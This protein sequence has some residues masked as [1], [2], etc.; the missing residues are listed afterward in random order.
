MRTIFHQLPFA[1]AKAQLDATTK[2]A[3]RLSLTVA[4]VAVLLGT[5]ARSPSF[6]V[7]PAIIGVGLRIAAFFTYAF[8]V[9]ANS[10]VG[11]AAKSV[12]LGYAVVFGPLLIALTVWAWHGAE[13]RLAQ[14][15]RWLVSHPV[16]AHHRQ[17]TIAALRAR[18]AVVVAPVALRGV[19]A[20]AASVVLIQR[21]TN[22]RAH[23]HKGG[24]RDGC[25]SDKTWLE[26]WP[27]AE[28]SAL[29]WWWPPDRW[30]ADY[31]SD[32]LWSFRAVLPDRF[33][34]EQMD[35]PPES[36]SGLARALLGQHDARNPYDYFPYIFPGPTMWLNSFLLL[37]IAAAV[38]HIILMRRYP[39]RHRPFRAA[40]RA[41]RAVCRRLV[42]RSA[43]PQSHVV[44][45]ASGP[46]CQITGNAGVTPPTNSSPPR[47]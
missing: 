17:Q 42:G 38:V 2:T 47:S 3:Q 13:A 44:A 23:P 46:P 22:F 35:R 9:P 40:C 5:W 12:N 7:V 24:G 32:G 31:I 34:D 11:E 15:I 28:H 29:S 37:A 33:F 36:I 20:L 19:L 6:D 41:F 14:E 16:H 30:C 39:M 21:F 27:G 43:R 26:P 18:G 45:T 8:A 4:I 1:D 10:F 25:A